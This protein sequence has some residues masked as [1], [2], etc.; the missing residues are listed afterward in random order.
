MNKYLECG[1]IHCQEL[2]GQV[3]QVL[4][5]AP[6]ENSFHYHAG[7]YV[8]FLLDDE[9]PRPFSIA[10]APHE[11]VIEFHIR[12]SPENTYTTKL[13]KQIRQ[14]KKLYI[15]GPYGTLRYHAKPRYPLIFLAAG[16]GFAPCKA[17]IEEAFRDKNHADIYL[18]W[19]ARRESDLYWHSELI[20]LSENNNNFCYI[21][22]LSAQGRVYQSALKQHQ[23]FSSYHVY[24]S[25]PAE[26][27][28]ATQEALSAYHLNPVHFYSDWLGYSRS[29]TFT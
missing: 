7:Q 15:Q 24:A 16:T 2:T 18:Y 20:K 5:Q 19:A 11:K 29:S 17:M 26:M 22:V 27:V 1:I 13:I 21:P 23:D 12:H 28:F 6:P 9:T 3:M 14:T 4:I 10:N 8:E 25:G